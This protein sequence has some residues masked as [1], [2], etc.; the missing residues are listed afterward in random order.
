MPP[1]ENRKGQA[2]MKN[3][4][5]WLSRTPGA[6]GLRPRGANS[7]V[8]G[9]GNRR[10]FGAAQGRYF[11]PRTLGAAGFCAWQPVTFAWV[12][13]IQG[14]MK[15][16]MPGKWLREAALLRRASVPRVLPSR[17]Q[18]LG[19]QTRLLQRQHSIAPFDF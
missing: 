5:S 14:E 8:R 16:M 2:P 17:L 13:S 19:C 15:N 4:C 6:F 9:A 12:C 10:K 3:P 1:G 11:Y 7:E 18:R